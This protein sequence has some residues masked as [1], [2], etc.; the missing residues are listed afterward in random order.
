M[1]NFRGLEEVLCDLFGCFFGSFLFCL[2]FF[3]P[4]TNISDL[5]PAFV[6]SIK[7]TDFDISFQITVK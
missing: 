5:T 1:F 4:E 6:N 7:S 3:F 2:F